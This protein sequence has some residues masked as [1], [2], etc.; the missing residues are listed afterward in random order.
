LIVYD[1]IA[2]TMKETVQHCIQMIT[3]NI[4]TSQS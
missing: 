2:S 4:A 3:N 1:N